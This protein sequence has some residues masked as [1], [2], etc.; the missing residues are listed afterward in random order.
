MG[1]KKNT[2]WSEFKAFATKG[3]VIDMAVGVVVGGAFSKIVSSLVADIIT[4]LISLVTGGSNFGEL[5]YVLKEGKDAVLAED[6]VTVLE[7]AIAPVTLNYGTFIQYI[8]DFVI[9]ALSIFMVVK[10]IAAVK[11]NT[12][13]LYEKLNAEEA[14]AA[15]EKAAAEKAASDAEAEAVKAA[16]E[17]EKAELEAVRN[18]Q[19]ET[20]SLLA[21]I[22]ELLQKK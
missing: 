2:F 21:D 9:I 15:A 19:K 13:K 1:K 11:N 12:A 8:I 20:A 16:A 10:I 14:K 6:G 5:V 18:A 7:E 17:A 4:P 22:K 3:N